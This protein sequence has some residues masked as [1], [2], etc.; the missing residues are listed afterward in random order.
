[1][2][3]RVAKHQIAKLF[4]VFEDAGAGQIAVFPKQP[5]VQPQQKAGLSAMCEFDAA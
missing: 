1:M 3:D 4:D 2:A 5:L